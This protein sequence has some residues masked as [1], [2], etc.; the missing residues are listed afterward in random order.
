MWNMKIDTVDGRLLFEMTW[1]IRDC[2]AIWSIFGWKLVMMCFGI[3]WISWLGMGCFW[4]FDG[5]LENSGNQKIQ[6]IKKIN[7]EN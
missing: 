5:I 4:N 6:K 1:K 2:F 7:L 3:W